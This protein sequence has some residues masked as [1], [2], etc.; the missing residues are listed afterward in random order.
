MR[1]LIFTTILS[2]LSTGCLEKAQT[3]KSTDTSTTNNSTAETILTSVEVTAQAELFLSKALATYEFYPELNAILTG[4]KYVKILK[5]S[6]LWDGI[7]CYTQ[8]AA[9][10]SAKISPLFEDAHDILDQ[11]AQEY[12]LVTPNSYA[13]IS[14]AQIKTEFLAKIVTIQNEIVN[15][16]SICEACA[17]YVSGKFN[18]LPFGC[19][20]KAV[21]ED[22]SSGGTLD[23]SVDAEI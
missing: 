6:D 17:A 11:I 9:E 16:H 2:L 12:A 14:K 13:A 5:P 10:F 18:D 22:P 7:L 1:I 8:N 15:K 3:R 23:P 4:T 20:S 19:S 21:V